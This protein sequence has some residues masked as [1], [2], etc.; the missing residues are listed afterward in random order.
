[1]ATFHLFPRLPTELRLAIW[2]LCLP[3]R[4]VEL[5]YQRD[6]LFFGSPPPCAKNMAVTDA[7]TRIPA[8]SLVNREA[9]RIALENWQSLPEIQSD[10]PAVADWAAEIGRDRT[11]AAD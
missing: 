4:V 5:D 2:R 9:R 7:N 1:M 3:R 10:S 6:D 8:L 11:T